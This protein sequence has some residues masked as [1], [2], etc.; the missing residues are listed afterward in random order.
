[1]KKNSLCCLE[2]VQQELL[3]SNLLIHKIR[4]GALKI[5]E[6]TY[7]S[8]EAFMAGEMK[9]GPIALINSEETDNKL[10]TKGSLK[11]YC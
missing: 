10:K 5:K 7:I 1:M 9:H 2:R 4:E 6:I 8:S 3:L 11:I